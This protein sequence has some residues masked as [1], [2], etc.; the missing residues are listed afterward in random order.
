MVSASFISTANQP[1]VIQT[2]HS[3][4]ASYKLRKRLRVPTYWSSFDSAVCIW[5][6]KLCKHLPGNTFKRM[7]FSLIGKKI[8]SRTLLRRLNVCPI[9]CTGLLLQLRLDRKLNLVKSSQSL[10]GTLKHFWAWDYWEETTLVDISCYL[11]MTLEWFV[12]SIRQAQCLY[13]QFPP[14]LPEA[15]MHGLNPSLFHFSICSKSFLF[16]L[17]ISI[18]ESEIYIFRHASV[19]ST[20]PCQ[21]V[22]P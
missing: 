15:W 5:L 14:H 18:S 16:L 13:K 6:R 17:S 2:W 12:L 1:D 21:S 3:I 22:G 19:S 11:G 8:S 7:C 20:Y 10:G 9:H 4:D